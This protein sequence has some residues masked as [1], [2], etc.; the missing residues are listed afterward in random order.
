MT[1]VIRTSGLTKRFGRHVLAVDRLDLAVEE[2][3]LYGFLGP[4]G[5]GKT[6]LV[7]M[8][9]GLVYPTA[10]SIELLGHRMPRGAG[11]ALPQVGA[12]VE[13]PAFYPHL[14]GRANLKLFDAAGVGGERRTRRKRI[15]AALEQVR[16]SG[17]AG[18]KVG[19]YSLG[20]KQRLGIAAALLRG[21]RLLV[22]DEPTNGLDP[23]GIREVRDLLLALHAAGTT[24]FLSSHLLAEVEQLCTVAGIVHRGRLVAERP[25]AELLAPSGRVHVRT[26]DADIA[27]TVLSGLRGPTLSDSNDAGLHVHLD[28]MPVAELV[29]RLVAGGVRIDEVAVHR[30]TLEDVYLE[31]T[32]GASDVG[33][34]DARS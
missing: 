19:A 4:N 34:D 21:P 26:V 14:S 13:G 7:R 24:V 29:A 15:D 17:A 18:R 23:S 2:G 33:V 5:S 9:L 22:L 3:A 6:T 30:P 8:L 31:L 11:D 27:L 20:M 12:L 1:D 16:L 25:V 28:G 10:G 32:G